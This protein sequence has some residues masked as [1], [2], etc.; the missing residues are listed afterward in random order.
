MGIFTGKTL[1]SKEYV[2]L[3]TEIELLKAKFEHMESLYRSLKGTVNRKLY[4][5]EE[6]EEE[7]PKKS[8]GFNSGII[9]PM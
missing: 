2:K 4:G 3:S 9:L 6:E 7:N 5:T 8:K 1:E